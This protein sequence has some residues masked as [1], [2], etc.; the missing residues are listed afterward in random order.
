MRIRIELVTFIPFEYLRRII[1]RDRSQQRVT[2]DL[3]IFYDI[4]LM[5]SIFTKIWCSFIVSFE[6]NLAK[7]ALAQK[8]FTLKLKIK[9]RL[10]LQKTIILSWRLVLRQLVLKVSIEIYDRSKLGIS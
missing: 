6:P 2:P 3:T 1:R 8:N 4:N 9:L 10:A 5:W 7:L